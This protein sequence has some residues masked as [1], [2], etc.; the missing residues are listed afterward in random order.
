MASVQG[1]RPRP[2]FAYARLS[3]LAVA[4]SAVAILHRGAPAIRHAARRRHALVPLGAAA[5]S[6]NHAWAPHSRALATLTTLPILAPHGTHDSSASLAANIWF[7]N[8]L[9]AT[10]PAAAYLA[11]WH[12]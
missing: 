12:R 7:I 3:R 6:P 4:D 8:D 10:R 11:S 1:G 5:D 2:V 9:L